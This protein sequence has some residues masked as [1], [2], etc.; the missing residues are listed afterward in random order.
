MINQAGSRPDAAFL[1]ADLQVAETFL[2][3]AEGRKI[4]GQDITSTV[5]RVQKALEA[6]E[7]LLAQFGSRYSDHQRGSVATAVVLLRKRLSTL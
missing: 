7:L 1:S 3:V 2:A 5:M 6:V 4:K